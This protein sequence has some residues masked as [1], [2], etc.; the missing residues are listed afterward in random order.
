MSHR[1]LWPVVAA[2]LGWTT[3]P[4][5]GNEPARS[6]PQAAAHVNNVYN[7]YLSG[8]E[9]Y[10]VQAFMRNR[11]SE[12][13]QNGPP[14]AGPPRPPSTPQA[15]NGMNPSFPSQQRLLQ[16][17]GL[18][19]DEIR[20]QGESEHVVQQVEANR[21]VLQ[22]QVLQQQ[23]LRSMNAQGTQSTAPN[24]MQQLM[25]SNGSQPFGTPQPP[26]MAPQGPPQVLMNQI[27]GQQGGHP[28]LHNPNGTVGM[29]RPVSQ[30][31]GVQGQGPSNDPGQRQ[32]Y[33]RPSAEQLFASQ[34]YIQAMKAE[35]NANR[36]Q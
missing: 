16:Y 23:A 11:N 22:R 3:F 21:G 7:M 27:T 24:A 13:H 19:A 30:L 28:G 1:D 9:A 29:P 8:F 6:A 26:Q 14:P 10:Y 33:S 5:N 34:R 25:Q 15:S 2:K 36:S 32:V 35:F 17:A 12:D 18:S 4:S 20:S 31:G